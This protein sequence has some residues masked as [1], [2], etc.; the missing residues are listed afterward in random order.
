MNVYDII[1][2]NFGDDS[3]PDVGKSWLEMS[4]TRKRYFSFQDWHEA[5]V[6]T[7]YIYEYLMQCGN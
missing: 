5:T 1:M 2:S 4:K 3:K 6:V 7:C